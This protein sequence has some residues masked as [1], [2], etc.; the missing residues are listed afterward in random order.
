MICFR[1]RALKLG[2][3]VECAFRDYGTLKFRVDM[4]TPAREVAWT[5]VQGPPEWIG[6][7]ISFEIASIPGGSEFAF[8]HTGLPANYEAHSTFNYLWG[9]YV[10]SIKCFAETGTGEPFGSALSTAAGTTPVVSET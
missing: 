6:S 8:R 3:I 10:R 9:Q 4:L 5:V 1:S 2:G 7:K